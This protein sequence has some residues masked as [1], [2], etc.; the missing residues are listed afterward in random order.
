LKKLEFKKKNE[1]KI[2]FNYNPYRTFTEFLSFK[3]KSKTKK[4]KSKTKK[5][6]SKTKKSK[7]K[8]KKSKSKIKTKSKLK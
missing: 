8:T 1:Y 4:S 6:K 7:S 5:S 3:F 2:W